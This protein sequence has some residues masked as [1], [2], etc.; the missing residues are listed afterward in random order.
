MGQGVRILFQV[1]NSWL[2]NS[3]TAFFF[4]PGVSSN[5][6]QIGKVNKLIH[7]TRAVS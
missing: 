3:V 7:R 6:I 1:C 4:L 5:L 2:F